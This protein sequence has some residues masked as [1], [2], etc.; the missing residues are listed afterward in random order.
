MVCNLSML[1]IDPY[2]WGALLMFSIV[3]KKAIVL[4]WNDAELNA[5]SNE[6]Q[7]SLLHFRKALYFSEILDLYQYTKNPLKALKDLYDVLQYFQFKV[8]FNIENFHSIW[9]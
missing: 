6:D 3:R 8:T 2:P 4:I 1:K 9:H 7:L 5:L